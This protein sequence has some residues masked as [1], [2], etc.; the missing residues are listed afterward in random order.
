MDPIFPRKL[1]PGDEVRVVAPSGSRAIITGDQGRLA[2]ARLEELGLRAT[3][4]AHVDEC[5]AFDSSSVDSRLD[6]LHAAFADPGVAAI[7]T[8]IGGFNVNQL[9]DGLDMDLVAANPKIV[10]GYSDITALSHAVHARTGLVTYAGPHWSTFAMRDHLEDTLEWFR[11]V[12]VDPAHGG[13]APPLALAPAAAWTD[14]AWYL[15]QDDRHPQPGEGWWVLAEGEPAGPRRGRVLGGNLATL[16]LL[17]GTRWMPD[18]TDAVLVVE[19][20][21][22]SAPH[23]LD[24]H[25]QAVLHQPGGDALAALVIGRFQAASGITRELLA[26][27]VAS[28]PQLAGVPVVANVDVGH[29]QPMWSYPIGGEAEVEVVGAEARIRLLTY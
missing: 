7:L 23:H 18:L 25:L 13:T 27:I 24:R 12:L 8:V 26:E 21:E 2:T 5:D 9:L 29:T 20:D 1:R 22:E 17:H 4:G 16:V 14:D 19:D 28:K 3:F 11:A 15:D 6:D 10:C